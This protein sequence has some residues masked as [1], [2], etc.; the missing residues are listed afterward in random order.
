LGARTLYVKQLIVFFDELALVNP[1]LLFQG[2]SIN[3]AKGLILDMVQK[4]VFMRLEQLFLV[5]I[6]Q[7]LAFHLVFFLPYVEKKGKYFFN[8]LL[9]LHFP[10]RRGRI[11]LL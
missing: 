4:K 1:K 8:L 5:F 11:F 2:L 6:E 10:N 7:M 9:S 3:F